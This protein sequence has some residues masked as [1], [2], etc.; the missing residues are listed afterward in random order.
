MSTG[1]IANGMILAR[2]IDPDFQTP[3][4]DDLVLGSSTAIIL[5]FPLLLL[6]AQAPRPGN[7][8]W[9]SLVIFIYLLVLLT[10]LLKD[11]LFKRKKV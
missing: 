6:I 8:W 2:E 1:T 7:L 4:G 3:A 9:V 11:V 5:G 10:Y